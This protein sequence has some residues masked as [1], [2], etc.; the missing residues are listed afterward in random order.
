[1]F[2]RLLYGPG[3][4][5][6]YLPTRLIWRLT[7]VLIQVFFG[8]L[9]AIAGVAGGASQNSAL[10]AVSESIPTSLVVQLS[11]T[12]GIPKFHPKM[13]APTIAVGGG[14]TG[15]KDQQYNPPRSGGK[16]TEQVG[17][18]AEEGR[19]SEKQGQEATTSEAKQEE[20]QGTV[21]RERNSEEP[22]NPKKRMWEENIDPPVQGDRARD[23][24]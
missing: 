16:L 14:G 24:L 18:M 19:E 10:S 4:W 22:P 3:W 8:V 9:S 6:L 2:R 17:K 23:E 11:A 5:L 7:I 15:A 1:M 20:R 13:S 21:L 12:G